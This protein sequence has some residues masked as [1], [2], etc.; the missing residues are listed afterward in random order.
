MF[1]SPRNVNYFWSSVPI[2]FPL[3]PVWI[4]LARRW[5]WLNGPS[6]LTVSFL[7]RNFVSVVVSALLPKRFCKF[8]SCFYWCFFILTILNFKTFSPSEGIVLMASCLGSYMMCLPALLRLLIKL[9]L[10]VLAYVLCLPSAMWCWICNKHDWWL[11]ASLSYERVG[12]SE[13]KE[14]DFSLFSL[15]L[16]TSKNISTSAWRELA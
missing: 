14:L 7:L 15:V 16:I 11:F 6:L 9:F 5:A 8:I 13:T 12:H 10:H 2:S 4:W 3:T 1:L